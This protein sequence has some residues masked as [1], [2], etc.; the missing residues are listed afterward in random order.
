MFL[1]TSFL[2]FDFVSI[3]MTNSSPPNL[4]TKSSSLST[5]FN[6]F[7]VSIKKISPIEC[8][9]ISLIILKL[10]KSINKSAP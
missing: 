3:R 7:A 1:I 2:S 8:P 5:S 10:S 6:L 4:A 9:L